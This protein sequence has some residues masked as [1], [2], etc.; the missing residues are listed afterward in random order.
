MLYLIGLG[1]PGLWH[2]RYLESSKK[3]LTSN[4]YLDF[5]S[6]DL[7]ALSKMTW[8]A[9]LILS[10]TFLVLASFWQVTFLLCV[11]KSINIPVTEEFYHLNI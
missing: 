2:Q 5:C 3:F 1:T 7:V 4:G 6:P 11:I 8:L 10:M 9:K